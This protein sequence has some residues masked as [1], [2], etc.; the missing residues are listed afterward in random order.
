MENHNR[1]NGNRAYRSAHLEECPFAVQSLATARLIEFSYPEINQVGV[2]TRFHRRSFVIESVRDLEAEPL[3]LAEINRRPSLRRS[4]FLLPGRKKGAGAAN[5][6][7]GGR[8][9]TDPLE[10]RHCQ[11]ITVCSS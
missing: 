10:R 7:P 5:T 2:W 8:S 4:R 11:H 9:R 1:P 6:N 3:T